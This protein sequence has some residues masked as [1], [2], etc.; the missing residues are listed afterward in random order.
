MSWGKKIVS[1]GESAEYIKV[2]YKFK[3]KPYIYIFK[4][5]RILIETS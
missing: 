3:K 1:V 5:E 4:S 2:Q